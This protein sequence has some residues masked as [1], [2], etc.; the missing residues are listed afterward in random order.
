MKRQNKKKGIKNKR[1]IVKCLGSCGKLFLSRDKTYNRI[2][3]ICKKINDKKYDE[4]DHIV[5]EN[6]NGTLSIS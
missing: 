6:E 1:E 2:C 4:E 3:E 5:R